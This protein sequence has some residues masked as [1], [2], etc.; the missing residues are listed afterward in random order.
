ML[1][2]FTTMEEEGKENTGQHDISLMTAIISVVS[3]MCQHM[4]EM[5]VKD[6][7]D[8]IWT[9]LPLGKRNAEISVKLIPGPN[10]F[11]IPINLVLLTTSQLYL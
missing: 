5:R 3:L 6:R 11:Y 4:V 8:P 9:I 7:M 1:R 10:L 2:F